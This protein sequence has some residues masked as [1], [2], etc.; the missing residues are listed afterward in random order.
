[1]E[2]KNKNIVLNLNQGEEIVYFY[3]KTKLDCFFHIILYCMMSIPTFLLCFIVSWLYGA[4]VLWI[5]TFMILYFM[6]RQIRDYFF[7]DLILT[8]QRI[9]IIKF[10][11][12]ISIEFSQIKYIFNAG[13]WGPL[14]GPPSVDI[15]LKNYKGYMVS[16]V[17]SK[18]LSRQ[19][20]LLYPE[21]GKTK[22]NS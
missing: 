16:F 13:I 17:D 19:L 12:L 7:V 3:N 2:L 10:N 1:M 14:W 15:R 21:Y 9:L 11:K 18:E 8:N 4:F 22:S 5:V 20:R 6:Y